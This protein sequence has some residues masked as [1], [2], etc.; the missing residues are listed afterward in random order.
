MMSHGG[1]SVAGGD[2]GPGQ[3]VTQP[4]HYHGTHNGDNALRQYYS[5]TVLFFV[6][7][8]DLKLVIQEKT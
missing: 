8:G 3:D 4:S 1:P 7:K 2:H 5:V 6:G